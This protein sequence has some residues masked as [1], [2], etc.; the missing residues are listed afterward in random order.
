MSLEGATRTRGKT[1]RVQD[2]AAPCPLDL[3]NGAR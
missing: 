2:K 1:I 3:P